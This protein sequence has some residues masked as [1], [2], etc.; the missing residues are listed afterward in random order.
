MLRHICEC[1]GKEQTISSEEAYAQGWDYPPKMGSFKIVSPRTCG[2]CIIQNTLWWEI[3]CNK[4]PP[5]QLS[6]R[7]QQ[8]LKRILT[9][10]E[11]IM[12]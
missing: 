9:E 11:S 3:T 10:P 2:E 6:E 7:H 12:P 5:G 1:C 8:T 4:T